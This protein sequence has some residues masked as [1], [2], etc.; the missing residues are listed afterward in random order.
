MHF[1]GTLTCNTPLWSMNCEFFLGRNF[2]IHISFILGVSNIL[3]YFGDIYLGTVHKDEWITIPWLS[4]GTYRMIRW[5]KVGWNILTASTTSS[6][7]H[8]QPIDL[9]CWLHSVLEIPFW[10]SS[11]FWPTIRTSCFIFLFSLCFLFCIL[12][13]L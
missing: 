8:L 2:L 13:T 10:S 7:S 6:P 4:K 12:S 3:Y 1:L 5:W 9:F 11:S